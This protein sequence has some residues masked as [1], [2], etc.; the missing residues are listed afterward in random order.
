MPDH[1]T[2][3]VMLTARVGRIQRGQGLSRLNLVEPDSRGVATLTGTVEEGVGALGLEELHQ[4]Q[5]R[6]EQ[7]GELSTSP[8]ETPTHDH[9]S[10]RKSGNYHLIQLLGK[11]RNLEISLIENSVGWCSSTML[12]RHCFRRP[13]IG[14]RKSGRKALGRPGT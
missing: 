10:P 11:E 1:K 3:K 8:V 4:V 5:A 12:I 6:A 2:T 13:M 14:W 7:N 9:L